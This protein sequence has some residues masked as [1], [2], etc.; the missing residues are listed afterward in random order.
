M[1]VN[2]NIALHDLCVFLR[3]ERVLI[4]SDLHLGY[5]ESLTDKGILIPHSQ[6]EKTDHR[7]LT[8]IKVLEPKIII[9]NGDFKHNFGVVQASEW[10]QGLQLLAAIAKQGTRVFV[11]EGNHDPTV[12]PL[13]RKAKVY[14]GTQLLVGNKLITHGDHVPQEAARKDIKTIIIGHEHPA[15]VVREGQRKESYKCF[16][17]GKWKN[18]RLIVMP[19]YNLI[20]EGSDV[21][22]VNMLS[23]FLQHSLG[24]FHVIAVGERL[25]DFGLVRDLK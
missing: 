25:L 21:L 5:E 4:I 15:L 19:S 8:T 23:P 7:I 12:G 9:F 20:T 11:I 3:E 24:S 18:K 16:L 17:V 2:N 10:R 13:L 6:F 1:D 22:S 14:C